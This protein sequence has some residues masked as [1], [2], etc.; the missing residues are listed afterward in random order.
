MARNPHRILTPLAALAIAVSVGVAKRVCGVLLFL[1]VIGKIHGVATATLPHLVF[2]LAD[3]LGYGDLGCYGAPDIR[4]PNLDRL[5]RE[6]VRLTDCYASAPVCS[7]TRAAFITG[8]YQQRIG[9]EDALYY[10][11]L[12][13]GLP[14]RGHTLPGALRQRG[15]A[16]ALSG[17]WHLGYDPKRRPNARGFD[18]FFGLLGGNHHYFEHMD[19][20]GVPDLF[21]DDR[22]I[23]REG[24]STDLITAQAIR[25]LRE[26][27]PRAPTFLFLS[28]NA[29]HFPFQGPDDRAKPVQPR[30]KNWQQGDRET[31]VAMVERMDHGI[32]EVLKEIDRLGLQERTLVV[33]TSD[34]GGDVHSRNAPLAG[35]KNMMLEG[36]VRVPGIARWSGVIPAGTVSSQ[37]CITMD[38]AATFRRAAG[39]SVDP[40]REDGIDLLP[41]LRGERRPIIRDLFWR[42]VKGPI[43]KK[44]DEGR[45]VRSGDWKLIEMKSG[46]RQLFN[47][48]EDIGETRNLITKHPVIARRLAVKLDHWEAD[49]EQDSKP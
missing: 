4:T 25:Y 36:G 11:E 15:Y 13:R 19:R 45:A 30:K 34:N 26:L 33:F 24:Y 32:G 1:G 39:R 49:F 35:G 17:K 23:E 28:Y 20:I 48:A 7:P 37:V 14:E 21:L 2:I 42:R 29:P 41:V 47:L 12:G 5:A 3:D 18:H 6:G 8:R 22:P 9:L 31:Y 44:V 46:D 40:R 16:T 10:Q 27:T 38:W 43:R